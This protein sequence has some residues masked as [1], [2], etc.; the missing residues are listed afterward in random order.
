MVVVF[1]V[2]LQYLQDSM[3]DFRVQGVLHHLQIL[4][5]TLLNY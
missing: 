2:E 3:E 4:R 1:L 5:E